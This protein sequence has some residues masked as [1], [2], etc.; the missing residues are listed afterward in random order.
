MLFRKI[1]SMVIPPVLGEKKLHSR[2]QSAP[3]LFDLCLLLPWRANSLSSR[4]L[5]AA[6]KILL[7][8]AEAGLRYG[9]SS[10]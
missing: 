2:D 6:D 3:N 7:G 5:S 1:R 4:F 9:I 8:A 10:L